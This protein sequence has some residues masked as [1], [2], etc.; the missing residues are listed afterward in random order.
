MADDNTNNGIALDASLRTFVYRGGDQNQIPTNVQKLVVAS[1]GLSHI[2]DDTWRSWKQ[3]CHL[4]I[5]DPDVKEFFLD[6][7]NGLQALRVLDLSQATGILVLHTACSLLN[8][9]LLPPNLKQI[10]TVTFSKS[11]V[12]SII[13]PSTTTIIGRRAF[14][15]SGLKTI[16]FSEP[17]ALSSMTMDF[18]RVEHDWTRID[19]G[20]DYLYPHLFYDITG[21]V[22]YPE[23]WCGPFDGCQGLSH[24]QWPKKTFDV[25]LWPRLFWHFSDPEGVFSKF[26]GLQRYRNNEKPSQTNRNSC[27]Y[28]FLRSN[29][30]DFFNK[31]H[32][33]G[34]RKRVHDYQQERAMNAIH[35]ILADCKGADKK[36]A[37]ASM[38]LESLLDL[39]APSGKM[40]EDQKLS[41]LQV[42][43]GNDES[44]RQKLSCGEK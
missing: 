44:K 17:N 21:S 32:I 37:R 30:V 10:G 4:A 24:I 22:E 19:D 1:G 20:K 16:V 28:N 25:L 29:V 9:I 35:H 7:T 3:L 38:V 27:L 23:S 40:S 5:T 2:L 39:L 34:S 13:I 36:K 41:V 18:M 11:K 42:V 26:W 33:E 15:D 6:E 14:G 12:T 8:T 43:F 31:K